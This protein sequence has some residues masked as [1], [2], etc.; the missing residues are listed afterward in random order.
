MDGN[1]LPG[2]ASL[3]DEFIGARY[4]T[5]ACLA[6]ILGRSAT[7]PC[8]H[9]PE[10]RPNIGEKGRGFDRMDRMKRELKSGGQ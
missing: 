10:A 2:P 6:K 3:R 9:E 1:F 8:G 7:K 4:Q 5:L